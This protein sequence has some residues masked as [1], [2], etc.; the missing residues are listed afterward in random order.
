MTKRSC[1]DLDSSMPVAFTISDLRQRPE[2]FG[3]VA[4][5]IWQAWWEADGT[6]LDHI[7]QPSARKHGRNAH[8]IRA[9]RP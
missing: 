2:F 1:R 6:P 4:M 7:F 9:G 8:S 3:T 5:R